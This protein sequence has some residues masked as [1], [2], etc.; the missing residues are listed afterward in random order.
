[1]RTRQEVEDSAGGKDIVR[2]VKSRWVEWLG[3]V[4]GKMRRIGCPRNLGGQSDEKRGMEADSA[5]SQGA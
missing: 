2:L 3:H 4:Q 1:M 5:G